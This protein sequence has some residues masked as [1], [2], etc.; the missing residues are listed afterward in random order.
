MIDYRIAKK[1]GGF[2][3]QKLYTDILKSKSTDRWY[4]AKYGDKVLLSN[5]KALYV[6]PGRYPLASGFIKESSTLKDLVPNWDSGVPCVYANPEVALTDKMVV[7]V[8]RKGKEDFYFN[9]DFFKYFTGGDFDYRISKD[10]KA[11]YVA[12]KEEL[13]AMIL[14]INASM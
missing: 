6:V 8:F 13:I 9:I 12:Y 4:V 11:L 3:L 2:N 14:R 5:C 1:Q 7:K 10:G